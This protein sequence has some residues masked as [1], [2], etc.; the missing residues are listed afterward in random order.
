MEFTAKSRT[1]PVTTPSV[2]RLTCPDAFS[3]TSKSFGPMKAMAIGWLRPSTTVDTPKFGST[4]TC[5]PAL[6]G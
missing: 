6:G 3:V 2:T 4:R 1:T 5:A